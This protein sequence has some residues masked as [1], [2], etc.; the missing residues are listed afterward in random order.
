MEV[1]WQELGRHST[2]QQL[3]QMSF[4]ENRR[5]Q[6]EHSGRTSTRWDDLLAQGFARIL[7]EEPLRSLAQ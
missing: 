7:A 2:C 4:E 3:G 1:R 6:P 5:F